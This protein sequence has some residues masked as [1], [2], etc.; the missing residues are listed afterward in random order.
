M[1][2]SKAQ[3]NDLETIKYFI[4]P[5]LKDKHISNDDIR[6]FFEHSERGM[7]KELLNSASGLEHI[8]DGL[9]ALIQGKIWRGTHMGMYEEGVLSGDMP[10]MIILGLCDKSYKRHWLIRWFFVL[11]GK[12]SYVF[13]NTPPPRSVVDFMKK[14]MFKGYNA[15]QI[16]RCYQEI[17]NS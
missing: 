5:G 17:L 10:Y 6:M 4:P 2:L 3:S 15:D 16:E 13:V 12:G 8:S 1:R 11:I 7:H 14:E 9:W